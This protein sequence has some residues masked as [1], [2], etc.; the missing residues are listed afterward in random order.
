MDETYFLCN[1]IDLK[2]IGS[3][4]KPRHETNY[5]Y[6]RFSI[7]ILWAGSAAGVNGPLICME[8]GKKVHPRLRGTNLVNICELPE[9]SCVIPNK[10][11][12]MDDEI[13]TK[14]VK[15]LSPHIR[16]MKVSNVACVFLILFSIYLTLHLCPS[17]FSS[18]CL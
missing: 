3:K 7:K 12:Y 15:V 5:S 11:E 13:L 14:V 1:D 6:S 18:D 17:K 9:G 16:K 8:K 4:Y 10:A 2:A